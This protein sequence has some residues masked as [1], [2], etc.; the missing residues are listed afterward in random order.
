MKKEFGKFSAFTFFGL[1]CGLAYVKLGANK[2]GVPYYIKTWNE[3]AEAWPIVLI[4]TLVV[5]GVLYWKFRMK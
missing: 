2:Q 5:A 3:V 1:L 4:I